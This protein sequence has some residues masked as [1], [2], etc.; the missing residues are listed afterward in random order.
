[1]L[2]EMRQELSWRNDTYKCYHAARKGIGAWYFVYKNGTLIAEM[3]KSMHVVNELT[4]YILYMVD[5]VDR[6]VLCRIT[7]IFHCKTY[8]NHKISHS[9]EGIEDRD[10]PHNRNSLP[11]NLRK[12]MLEKYDPDFPSL[13]S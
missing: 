4:N 8:E 2:I 9:S 3:Q 10:M 7:C 6:D 5:D 13:A 12:E 1:M 11:N